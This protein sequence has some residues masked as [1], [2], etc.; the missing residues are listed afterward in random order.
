MCLM[1]EEED[2]YFLYLEQLER[3]RQAA[4]GARPP[5]D[6][7]WLW[8]TFQQ[9][10]AAPATREPARKTSNSFICDTPE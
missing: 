9:P 3:A 5:A 8:P 6:A 1:C 10:S 2:R 7:G 4:R